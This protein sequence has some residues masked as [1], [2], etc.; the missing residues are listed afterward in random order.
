LPEFLWK[1][2]KE[3]LFLF[4]I[5][6]S[7]A[8]LVSQ[9]KPRFFS[10]NLRQGIAFLLVPAQKLSDGAAA[11]TREALR[12]IAAFGALQGENRDLHRELDTLRLDNARLAEAAR[13]NEQLR[14]QLGYQARVPWKFIPAEVIGRD[15]ASW[16]ERVVVN[17]GTADGVRTGAGVIT[18][19]GVVGRV[20][21][22]EMYSAPIMLLTEN[23]LLLTI[24]LKPRAALNSLE[25]LLIFRP[26]A[27]RP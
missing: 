17:R 23:G 9:Q 10:T 4:L 8:M 24:R 15:P 20:S 21:E 25:H 22:A 27:E 1:W 12:F 26:Q 6:I 2:R 18:P 3:I 19:Q 5:I 13:E 14:E 16:L 7:L 11:K